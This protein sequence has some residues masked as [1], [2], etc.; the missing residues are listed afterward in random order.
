MTT[1]V[2]P[3]DNEWTDCHRKTNGA[4]NALDR[5]TYLRSTMFAGRESF[6]RKTLVLEHQDTGPV[7][8]VRSGARA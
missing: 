5:L 1:G 8:S 3:G 7:A 2:M 6:G 4:F